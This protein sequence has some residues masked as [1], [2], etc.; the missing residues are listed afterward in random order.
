MALIML[1]PN[2]RERRKAEVLSLVLARGGRRTYRLPSAIE[3]DRTGGIEWSTSV[4]HLS[5]QSFLAS[6]SEETLELL[7]PR[8]A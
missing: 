6:L 3:L 1:K 4:I 2:E 5:S 7:E 8:A